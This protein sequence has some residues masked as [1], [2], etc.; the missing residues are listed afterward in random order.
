MDALATVEAW[1]VG[2]VAVAVVAPDGSVASNGDI[3]EVFRIASVTKLFTTYATLIAVEEG[4]VSLDDPAGPPGATLRH[5][6]AHTAGYGFDGATRQ[7]ARSNGEDGWSGPHPPPAP[8]AGVARR[9]IYSNAGMEVAADHVA[10]C[11]S[12]PFEQYLREAVFEPLGMR[13]STLHGSPAHAMRSTVAD[14]LRFVDEL[15]HPTLIAGA[16]LAEATTVQFPGLNGVVPGIGRQDPCD[17]G[18]GFEVRDHKSPHWTGTRNS[19]ET[20]G[21]FGGAGT[22]VWVDPA[23]G[24]AM[25]CLTDRDFGA[26]ALEE[27]PPLSDAVL[28]EVAGT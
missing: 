28:A 25:V 21:H 27:W 19:P 16:T 5:L 11:T 20:Y 12:M 18:L 6:L 15:R 13:S 23:A 9:R 2:S 1:D 3:D 17:W 8:I 4:S 22:F 26:W 24:V 14:L 10:E 7:G